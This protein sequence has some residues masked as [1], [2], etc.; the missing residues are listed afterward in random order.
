MTKN[1]LFD[2]IEFYFSEKSYYIP[3]DPTVPKLKE[4][5]DYYVNKEYKEDF[6]SF[7]I[8]CGTVLFIK[9]RLQ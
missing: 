9:E 5:W 7:K 3:A 6:E 2:T 8:F 1:K 4:W